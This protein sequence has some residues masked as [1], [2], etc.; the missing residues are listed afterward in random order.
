MRIFRV[1][2][3]DIELLGLG[4]GL[5]LEAL[6]FSLSTL[7]FTK[8]TVESTFGSVHMSTT[9]SVRLRSALWRRLAPDCFPVKHRRTAVKLETAA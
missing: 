7:A 6:A 1:A 9:T 4:W 8:L 3:C 5:E 2:K